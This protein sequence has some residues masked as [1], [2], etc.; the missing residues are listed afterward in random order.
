[1]LRSIEPRELA[2]CAC[3]GYAQLEAMLE[4]RLRAV[5]LVALDLDGTLLT[6]DSHV[7]PTCA[8]AIREALAAGVRVV[9]AT[10]RILSVLPEAL[11]GVEG[12]EYAVGCAGAS[13]MR[14]GRTREESELLHET[15][16]TP[17][18][19]A[20]LAADLLGE[21]S[22]DIYLD[23]ACMGEVF[24]DEGQ[25]ALLGEMGL[26]A[27]AQA[28]TR[29]TRHVVP[30]L[31]AATRAFTE[32]VG[33]L[34]IFY[35]DDE[36]RA[37]VMAWLRTRGGYELANSLGQNIEVN[38]PGTSKWN[39]IEWLCAHLSIDGGRV[40]AI[41]DGAN[42]VDMIRRAWL[43]VAMK[44]AVPVAVDAADA[45]TACT[46]DQDGVARVLRELIELKRG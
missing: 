16:L 35:R 34:N 8:D 14:L 6:S 42:D 33:H 32:P 27:R 24:T 43:G 21:F 3:D 31:L 45:L 7:T 36:V 9:P 38:A 26:D 28:F 40:L 22:P 17:V 5:E 10:G 11:F 1:M 18:D 23:V 39:G 12:M 37:R 19:A 15:G 2:G 30:D 4:A 13:I 20:D 29:R 46:N 44:N 41:G 25:L